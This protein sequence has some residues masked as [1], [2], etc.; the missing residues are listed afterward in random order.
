ML[1]MS[2]ESKSVDLVATESIATLGCVIKSIGSR[3]KE[4][5]MLYYSAVIR[6]HLRPSVQ[7]QASPFKGNVNKSIFRERVVRTVKGLAN[8]R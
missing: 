2:H 6:P 3:I 7:L 5:I 1:I 4:V 8:P